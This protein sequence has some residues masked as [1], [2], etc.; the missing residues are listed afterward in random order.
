MVDA[1]T[2]RGYGG[3]LLTNGHLT[4]VGGMWPQEVIDDRIIP[5]ADDLRIQPLRRTPTARLT[6]TLTFAPWEFR[7]A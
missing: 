6:G 5:H 2:S 7:S 4:Y 1:A 3:V